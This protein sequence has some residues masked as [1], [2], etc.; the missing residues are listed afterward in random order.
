MKRARGRK[1]RARSVT[2]RISTESDV[3]SLREYLGLENVSSVDMLHRNSRM[4][5]TGLLGALIVDVWSWRKAILATEEW[6]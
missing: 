2:H 4:C 5:V 3:I 6:L 1:V